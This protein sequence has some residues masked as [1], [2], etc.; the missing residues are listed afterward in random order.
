MTPGT[1]FERFRAKVAAYLEEHEDHIALQR[2]RRN[3]QLTQDDL[4]SLEDMLAA[5]GGQRIDI[6]WASEQNGGLGLFI[7]SLV[8]LDHAAATEAFA[9][10]LDD[11]KYTV[12]QV[13]FIS[14]VV[15]ELTANGVMEPERLFESPYTDHAPTGPDHFLPDA[16]VDVIVDILHGVKARALPTSVA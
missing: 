8:G 9:D 5:A 15:D 11:T 7:R 13:R 2:L 14:L 1:N 12:D 6:A 4:T 16:D 3:K 10:Y